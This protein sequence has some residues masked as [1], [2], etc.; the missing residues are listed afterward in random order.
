MCDVI[1]DIKRVIKFTHNFSTYTPAYA[2]FFFSQSAP[3]TSWVQSI[4]SVY[5]EMIVCASVP[6]DSA[7]VCLMSSDSPVTT[8]HQTT[9]TWPVAVGVNPVTVTPTMPTQQPAMRFPSLPT[10]VNS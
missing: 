10:S 2:T 9:G 1:N 6:Q 8:A 4:V 7:S 5:P 3:A